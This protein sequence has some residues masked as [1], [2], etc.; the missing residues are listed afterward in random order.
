MMHR[1]RPG[2]GLAVLSLMYMGGLLST[3]F[4][5]VSSPASSAVARRAA[6]KRPPPR[7]LEPRLSP[8]DKYDMPRTPEEE[9]NMN[10]WRSDFDDLPAEEKLQSPLVVLGFFLLLTPFI[11]GF[12]TLVSGGGLDD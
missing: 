9:K 10:Y 12:Y 6:D 11:G 3:P 8:E 1:R 4:V 5:N 7:D 2:L